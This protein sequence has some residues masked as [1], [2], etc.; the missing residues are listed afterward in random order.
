MEK[1]RVVVTGMGLVGPV[2][3]NVS[4]SWENVVNGRSGIRPITAFDPV[5]FRFKT[6]IAGQAWGF[7]LKDA[8]WSVGSD[9]IKCLDRFSQLTLAAAMEA[10]EQAG[11]A[12]L[13]DFERFRVGVI[14]AGGMGG[15]D[16][17][18]TEY[19]FM[20]KRVASGKRVVV[21]AL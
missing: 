21:S 17:I 3:L 8:P 10:Y 2:G 11:I 19:D 14:A 6:R 13:N 20:L 4:D 1:R 5:D 16:T 9:E 15:L 12:L 18:T 7:S